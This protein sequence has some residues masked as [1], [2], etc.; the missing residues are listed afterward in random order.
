MPGLAQIG[1]RGLSTPVPGTTPKPPRIQRLLFP[2]P[3]SLQ[4][5]RD[6]ITLVIALDR[7]GQASGELY[8]DDG[9][10][11]AFQ[12]CIARLLPYRLAAHPHLLAARTGS[13]VLES[14]WARHG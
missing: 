14:S 9:R 5:A 6:P 4:M 1:G 8:V 2:L 11:F 13:D 10:S 3:P 7:Q 12:V